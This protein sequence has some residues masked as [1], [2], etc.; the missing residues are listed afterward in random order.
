MP[1][2]LPLP[3]ASFLR[4]LTL[5]VRERELRA[6]MARPS[7]TEDG[8]WLAVVWL[9]DDEGVVSWRE[10][11]PRAGPPPDPPL[12]RLGPILSGALSGLIREEGGRLGV[13]LGPVAPPDDPTQPW[14]SPAALRAAFLF[15]PL[16]AATMTS[17]QLA[18]TVL[19]AFAGSVESLAGR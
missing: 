14:R 13:R 16:R 9:A 4:E 19:A 15:E 18:S 6:G 7:T 5:R 3:G 17:N 2:R 11:A 8:W 1:E 12:V 10:I